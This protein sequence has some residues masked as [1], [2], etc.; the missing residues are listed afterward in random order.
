VVLALRIEI[1]VIAK[2][3]QPN[4]LVSFEILDFLYTL[5]H[6]LLKS[7]PF[8]VLF[9]TS[10]RGSGEMHMHISNNQFEKNRRKSFP[11]LFHAY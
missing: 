1:G 6:F 11:M 4:E 9:S 7:S 10:A 3:R 8:E 5:A 2:G